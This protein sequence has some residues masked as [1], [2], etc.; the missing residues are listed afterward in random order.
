MW[1]LADPWYLTLLVLPLGLYL[2]HVFSARRGRAS[3]LFSSGELI[4]HLPHTWRTRIAPHVHRTPVATSGALAL[5]QADSPYVDAD[6]LGLPGI[7]LAVNA[8][9]HLETVAR[10]RFPR[11]TILAIPD[12]QAVLDAL[13]GYTVD[14]VVTDDLE[15]DHWRKRAPGLRALGPLSRDRKAYLWGPE[16][17]ELARTAARA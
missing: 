13:L 5:V 1:R 11:A 10:T 4:A 3:I 8:G 2:W 7:R 17:G 14:A 6:A 9:G 16:Q 15:Q 12:N